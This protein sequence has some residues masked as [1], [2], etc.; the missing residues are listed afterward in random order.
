MRSYCARGFSALS[1]AID[2]R[3]SWAGSTHRTAER[4]VPLRG[5]RA[6]DLYHAGCAIG[7]ERHFPEARVVATRRDLYDAFGWEFRAGA[8]RWRR[9]AQRDY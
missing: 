6:L 1:L 8:H 4:H 3:V 5:S 9:G 7:A 2:T